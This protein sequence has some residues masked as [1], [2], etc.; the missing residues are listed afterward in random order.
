[1]G[2]R[3]DG[4]T[5]MCYFRLLSELV[6]QKGNCANKVFGVFVFVFKCHQL[7][8]SVQKTNE[9]PIKEARASLWFHFTFK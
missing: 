3:N 6:A 1:M 8:S 9:I 2:Y 5:G 4:D 7:L